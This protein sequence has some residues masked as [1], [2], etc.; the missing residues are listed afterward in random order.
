MFWKDLPD[1]PR[2][3]FSVRSFRPADADAVRKIFIDGIIGLRWL[4]YSLACMHRLFWG[5]P[6]GMPRL[7]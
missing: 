2:M 6:T 3:S 1:A 7:E 5:T 4:A